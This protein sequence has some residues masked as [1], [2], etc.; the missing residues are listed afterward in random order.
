MVK[1]E[2][3]RGMLARRR[4]RSWDEAGAACATQIKNSSIFNAYSVKAAHEV[5]GGRAWGGGG[6]LES[7]YWSAARLAALQNTPQGIV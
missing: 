2:C 6:H 5:E 1:G 3:C 7:L 4:R